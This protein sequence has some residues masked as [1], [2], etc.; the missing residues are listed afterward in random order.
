MSINGKPRGLTF[1]VNDLCHRGGKRFSDVRPSLETSDLVF[2]L[3]IDS[4]L[5]FYILRTANSS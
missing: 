4:R 2:R 1:R 3:Y 5:T